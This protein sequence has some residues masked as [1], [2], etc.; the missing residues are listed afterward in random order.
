MIVVSDTST[1]TNLIRIGRLNLLKLLFIEVIVPSHV[2]EE[3]AIYEKQQ[4]EIDGSV[5]IKV[6][7]VSNK[8][9]VL[10]LQNYLDTGE[11]EAIVLAIEL[12][13]DLIIMDER[14]GRAMAESYGLP[15]VGLLGILVKSAKQG[16]IE[17]LKPVLDELIVE[18]G[19][20]VHKNLYN[21]ILQEVNEHP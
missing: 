21:R 5:W 11:A 4:V 2:Y 8:K 12:K 19:F 7:S 17:R 13:A 20:R 15:V 18:V 16:H 3:L 9:E 14:K 6:K 10:E 1:I